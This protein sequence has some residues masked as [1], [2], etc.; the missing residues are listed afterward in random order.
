MKKRKRASQRIGAVLRGILAWPIV[1][2]F[3]VLGV[4]FALVSNPGRIGHMA[5]EIDCFLKERELGL[6]PHEKPILLLDRK[7]AG[8]KALLDVYKAYFTVFDKSWQRHLLAELTKIDALRYSL[9]RPILGFGECARYAQVLAL[10]GDRP[11]AVRLPNDIEALGR[12]RLAAMG[13]PD[14]AWFAC[15]HVREGGYSPKDEADHAHRNADI[16]AFG[17]AI[18]AITERGGWVIRVGDA[19]MAPLEDMPQVVD[20]ARS[21]LKA[22]WMDLWLCAHNR[23]FVGTTSGLTMVANMFGR[24]CALVNMIPHG[25]SLGQGPNDIS[26]PKLLLDRDGA[27]LNLPEIFHRNLSRQRYAHV[28]EDAGVTILDNSPQEIRE[29]VVEMMDRLDDSF[30]RSAEDEILQQRYRA[31]LRPEDYCFGS[32]A[33]IGR[34]WL[35]QNQSLL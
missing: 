29:L 13:V 24:P 9:G 10:W 15:V 32:S 34:D 5:A 26:I 27:T 33:S 31:H 3:A 30:E 17:S 7:R 25:A 4:R 6:I 19:T 21:P 20:Y 16:G 22:D 35:R 2:I 18:Q 14:G 23:F 12:N 28:F 11:P 8:N 1:G